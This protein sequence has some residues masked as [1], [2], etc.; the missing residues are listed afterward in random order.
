MRLYAARNLYLS[1]AA[2]LID[3]KREINDPAAVDNVRG[4]MQGF[5]AFVQAQP[6]R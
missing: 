5:A 2:T 1:R 6:P 3:A 4:W